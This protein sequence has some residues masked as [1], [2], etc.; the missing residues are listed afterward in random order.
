MSAID[1]AFLR[2]YQATSDPPDGTSFVGP[3]PAAI[4]RGMAP[5]EPRIDPGATIGP[6]SPHFPR[7][8][9]ATERAPS[10]ASPAPAVAPQA[11]PAARGRRP[12]SELKQS[13]PLVDA[14]FRPALE[15]D[16]FRVSPT[17]EMLADRCV[18]D[19]QGAIAAVLAAGEEGRTVVGVAGLGAG[20]GCS[21]TVVCLA[22]LAARQGKRVAL[23]DGDFVTA[24]L[25]R[26]LGLE[27]DLGWEDVLAGRVP[28]AES[29]VLSLA[30]NATLLPLVQGGVPAAEKLDAIHASV[31]AGVLRYHHDLVLVDLGSVAD[32]VQAPIARRI[33]R[34]CRLD[35]VVLAARGPAPRT[36]L[37]HCPELAAAMLGVVEHR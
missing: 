22:R 16:A 24:G 28:L 30:D 26:E 20:A 19:W 35:A 12:L 1:Q 31:A 9:P 4:A 17:V 14:A 18:A 33:A 15:V 32:P 5:I 11:E 36:A 34:Q 3:S 37:D 25:A 21:T 27:V 13:A 10:Y 6:P 2:A 23:V 29:S 7:V 8:A